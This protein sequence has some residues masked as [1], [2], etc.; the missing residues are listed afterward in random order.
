MFKN[1]GIGGIGFDTLDGY[2]LKAGSPCIDSGV[3][4]TNS[5]D[6]DFWGNKVIQGLTTDIGAFE[7]KS[8][9]NSD[10]NRA[11]VTIEHT[12]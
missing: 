1:P 7:Q 10:S 3:Y 9:S 6:K 8:S 4:I 5:A 2:K 12:K 11:T